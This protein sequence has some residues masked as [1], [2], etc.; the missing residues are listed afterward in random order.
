MA[1][2]GDTFFAPAAMQAA[3]AAF[4]QPSLRRGRYAAAQLWKATSVGGRHLDLGE[5]LAPFL[6]ESRRW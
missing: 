1:L 4:D 6:G 5:L 2:Y 3:V